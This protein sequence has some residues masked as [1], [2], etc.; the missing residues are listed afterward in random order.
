MARIKVDEKN[1]FGSFE[2]QSIREAARR[3]L[4]RHEAVACWKHAQES[5]VEQPDVPNF[6]KNRGAEQGDVDGPLECSLALGQVACDARVSIALQQRAGTLPWAAAG[7]EGSDDANTDFD[8]RRQSVRTF[9]ESS[10]SDDPVRI[11]P[12]NEIQVN[13]G[14]A[15]FWYLD[16]GDVLCDPR[17]VLPYL[18]AFDAANVKVGAERNLKKTEVV[19]FASEAE[20]ALHGEEW[21]TTR[22]AAVASVSLASEGCVTLGIATGPPSAVA[23]QLQT[24]SD[25]VRA[26]HDKLRVCQDPQTEFVLAGQCLGVGKVNH[27]LRV[28]GC[29]AASS[30]AVEKFDEI[31]RTT[32]ERL[33]PGLTEEGH[34]QATLGVKSSGL[35]WKQA[36]DVAG[37]AH[38][39]GLIA[40]GPRVKSM[41]QAAAIAG[42]LPAA[43][44]ESRLDEGVSAA[45]TSYLRSLDEVEKVRAEEF[46]AR[47]KRM[48]TASWQCELEGMSR[49]GPAPRVMPE[50]GDA[51]DEDEDLRSTRLSSPH[52]QKELSMLQDK[53]RRRRLENTLTQQGAWQQL[54]RIKELSN[55]N[56]SHK[57]VRHLDVKAGSV[58]TAI[59]FVSNVQKRLGARMCTSAIHCR[60]C[61]APLDAQLEHAETCCTAEAT[62]GHY[63]V[64]RAVVDGLKLADPAVTTEPRGLTS[65]SSRPADILTIAAVPGRSAAL[66]VCVASPNA[67]IARGDAAAAAFARKL[68]RYQNEIV[69]LRQA[70]ISFRPLVWTADGRP[71]A[72]VT[73][74]LRYAADIAAHRNGQ[75]VS[76][77]RLVSRWSHEIQIA[78]LRRRAAMSRAVLPRLT[79]RDVWLLAGQAERDGGGGA[80]APALD[81]DGLSANGAEG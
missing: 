63:A 38:L 70:G 80:R 3:S 36:S 5:Y 4:P 39:G 30:R 51:A 7:S 22:V 74:T 60:L 34:T 44:I 23:E 73:R 66:D 28:H 46:I 25:V 6:A 67:S 41:I 12:R 32:L 55:K 13:G 50:S 45:E 54:D 27:I 61:G 59:D 43:A 9:E 11:D 19:Y 14:I 53:T 15:D 40:A 29:R 78:I 48:A 77:G 57:W 8:R 68:D 35:G 62:R 71:H 47:A 26:M 52:L 20:L 69:E 42:L 18:T 1:C 17:L 65:T 24:K 56:V 2:W 72:A 75:Q 79:A 31:G 16:D 81:E 10:Q 37:A 58:L 49:A 64:V 21:D 33:V 76:A